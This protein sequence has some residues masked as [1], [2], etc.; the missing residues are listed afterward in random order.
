MDKVKH[1]KKT[2]HLAGK[3]IDAFDLELK[4][5]EYSRSEVIDSIAGF[6]CILLIC[7]EDPIEK[8]Q[9][10]AKHTTLALEKFSDDERTNLLS[11]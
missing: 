8:M 3:L 6:L 9:E 7:Q 10:I 4:V 2:M 5:N 1:V 11:R